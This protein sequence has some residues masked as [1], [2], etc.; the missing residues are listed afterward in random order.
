EAQRMRE[1]LA[2]LRRRFAETTA[3]YAAVLTPAATGEAPRGLSDTGNPLFSKPF[4]V[5]YGPSISVPCI[6]GPA[7]LPVGIQVASRQGDDEGAL[8]VAEWI[9]AAIAR[10][11]P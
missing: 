9:E 5:L 7:G 4:T 6:K 1:H 10:T 3:P 8:A 2:D 11:K